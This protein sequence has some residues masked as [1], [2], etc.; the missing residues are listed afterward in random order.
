MFT[1]TPRIQASHQPLFLGE[2]R[3]DFAKSSFITD[4]G[5]TEDIK[6]KQTQKLQDLDHIFF[7]NFILRLYKK[8][9][10]SS[11]LEINLQHVSNSTYPK[12]NK[13]KTSLVD[14]LDNTIK[15]SIDYG[16]QNKDLFFNTK[17]SAF[18]N[19]SKTGNERFEFIYPEASLE[20]NVLMS[21]SLGIV[22]LKSDLLVRNYEVDKQLDII[23]NEFNWV[24]NSW[25][26]KFGFENEFVGLFKNVNYQAKNTDDFKTDNSVSEFY[27]ALGFKSE[28]G[29]F[30]FREN[31]KLNVFK[32]KLLV[33][34]SPNDSRNISDD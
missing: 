5:Y 30:K 1:F 31:N 14:Y 22:D 34:I 32:P 3:Q 15:N 17:V 27:G 2:Y 9:I 16:Y 24:S 4:V 11:D 23:S 19:L 20:K 18:E 8:Q 10:I 13:L 33:K 12:V 7:L 21:E 26:N 6:K 28:L 25:V 29:L